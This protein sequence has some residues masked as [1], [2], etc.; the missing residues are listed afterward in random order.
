[1]VN[2]NKTNDLSKLN[3]DKLLTVR[4]LIKLGFLD[5][6]T[7]R[8]TSVCPLRA[9][10]QLHFVADW[11]TCMYILFL[12]HLDI[13]QILRHFYLLNSNQLKILRQIYFLNN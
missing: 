9:H 5:S 2:D 13:R 10:E 6:L 3:N 1:M 11:L 4:L 7:V 12:F 8:R